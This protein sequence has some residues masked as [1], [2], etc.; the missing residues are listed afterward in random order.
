MIGKVTEYSL[1]N[2]SIKTMF[3]LTVFEILLFKGNL[4]LSPTQ[5]GAESKRVK[6]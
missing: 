1:S 6:E 4:V 3:T 2:V 5:Q